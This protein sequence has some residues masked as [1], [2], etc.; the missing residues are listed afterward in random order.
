MLINAN[1]NVWWTYL[2]CGSASLDDLQ[3]QQNTK[4]SDWSDEIQD[5]DRVC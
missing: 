1:A 5:E 3:I 4:V 2:D